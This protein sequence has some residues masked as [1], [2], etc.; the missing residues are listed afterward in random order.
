MKHK[1]ISVFDLDKI[2]DIILRNYPTVDTSR[3]LID[4]DILNYF[5]GMD[6]KKII[7]YKPDHED[8]SYEIWY[9]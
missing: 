9:E 2:R 7:K 5:L 6:I 1:H 3:S 8:L 4:K